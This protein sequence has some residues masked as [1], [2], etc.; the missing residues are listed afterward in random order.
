MASGV[1]GTSVLLTLRA[2]EP[3]LDPKRG[4]VILLPV[5]LTKIKGKARGWE[6]VFYDARGGAC[7]IYGSRP[8]E[9]R[10]LKCWD[11]TEVQALFLKDVLS[12]RDVLGEESPLYEVIVSYERVFDLAVVH[13]LLVS[14]SSGA[15]RHRKT[16]RTRREVSF[17]GGVEARIGEGG[18]G[19]LLWKDD[20]APC[21][22]TKG[23]LQVAS[24][25][26]CRLNSIPKEKGPCQA[27]PSLLLVPTLLPRR[28]LRRPYQNRVRRT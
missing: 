13:E 12:R 20:G 18:T 1:L 26:T 23:L 4:K 21:E 19:V 15:G 8:L 28:P 11:T 6:C 22:V 9:C 5:E 17:H 14:G 27:G 16:R 2:G 10:A 7:S 3:A 25:R 24:N